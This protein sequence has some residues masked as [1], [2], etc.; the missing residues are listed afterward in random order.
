MLPICPPTNITGTGLPKLTI[1]SNT[2]TGVSIVNMGDLTSD[3]AGSIEYNHNDT[4]MQ[5]HV[6][7]TN[8]MTLDNDGTLQVNKITNFAKTGSPDANLGFIIIQF[9]QIYEVS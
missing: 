9:L 1:K 2:D 3:T 8:R 5:F 4:N 7:E 6:E